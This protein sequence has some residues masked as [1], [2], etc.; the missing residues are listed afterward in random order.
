MSMI[1]CTAALG[2]AAML[3]LQGCAA[4]YVR[5]GHVGLLVDNMSG[6]I[7]R[8][9]DPGFRM[10]IPVGQHIVEYPVIKQQYV[11]VRN[12]E[13]QHSDADDSVTV[14]SEEGQSFSADASVEYMVH[15]KDDVAPLYQRY[16]MSFDDVVEKYYR[17]KF[18]AAIA[19]A[20]A[21]M[22]LVE[23]ISGP[24]RK[25]IE[26]MALT[27]LQ[28]EL[29]DDHIDVSLVMIRT[30]YVPDAIANSIAEKTKAENELVQARTV[31]Q[32][33][34]VQA[35]AEAKA[36]LIHAKAEAEANREIN[37]S[38]TD[39]L[40]RRMYVEKLSDKIRMVVPE[41]S[42]FN[43]GGLAPAGGGDSSDGSDAPARRR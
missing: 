36:K 34:V 20:F 3:S 43:F 27:D 29:K 17:S 22:P 33:Q 38:L 28:N 30:V 4:S 32:Q 9:L 23:A 1:R 5:Q 19:N 37:A 35:E 18:R 14:N 6:K 26:A 12:A 31:A 8:V 2:L 13:G 42:F 40:I 10:A 16:G 25:K 15:S 39:R 24:G 11:M 41:R 7:D 21:S